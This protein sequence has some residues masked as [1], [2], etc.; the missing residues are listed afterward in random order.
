VFL[1]RRFLVMSMDA[2]QASLADFLR[3]RQ[4]G[5]QP[6][7][8][9]AL[10]RWYFQQIIL[11]VHYCH[12]RNVIFRDLKPSNVLMVWGPNGPTLQ[13]C[14]FGWAKIIPDLVRARMCAMHLA[15]RGDGLCGLS[16]RT[17]AA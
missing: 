17:R 2:A 11:T 5:G 8:G 6:R 9:V 12:A 16:S 15:R 10:A 13:L 3:L 1:T 4:T 7:L 14:D